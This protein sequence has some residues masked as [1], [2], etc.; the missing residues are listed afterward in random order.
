M[1]E[2]DQH[3]QRQTNVSKP[4]DQH[5][6][7]NGLLTPKTPYPSRYV[8]ARSISARNEL[9]GMR[10][11]SNVFSFIFGGQISYQYILSKRIGR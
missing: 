4:F 10:I 5:F 2:G 6:K 11:V 1:G 7:F 8:V 9:S 3:D